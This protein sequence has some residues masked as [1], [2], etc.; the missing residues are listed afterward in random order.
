MLDVFAR[1]FAGGG[2][3]KN[4]REENKQR[5]RVSALR[6]TIGP[7]TFDV[8]VAAANQRPGT[9]RYTQVAER[10]RAVADGGQSTSIRLWQLAP[11]V[12]E[13]DK[14]SFGS[15]LKIGG[16]VAQGWCVHR[17]NADL[18]VVFIA[19]TLEKWI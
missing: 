9:A 7:A 13:V 16:R 17:L 3:R 2:P 14:V 1:A 12:N 15:D 5:D 18:E 6:A 8:L 4:V 11:G 19:R 10:L